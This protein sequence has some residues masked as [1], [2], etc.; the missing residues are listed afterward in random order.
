[1]DQGVKMKQA[2]LEYIEHL[3]TDLLVYKKSI[4]FECLI[5]T[6]SIKIA[7]GVKV[8]YSIDGLFEF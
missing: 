4:Y 2:I 8:T 6:L 1:M 7:Q 3:I 5:H